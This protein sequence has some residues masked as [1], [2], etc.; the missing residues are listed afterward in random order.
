MVH[1]V[2]GRRQ[3]QPGAGSLAGKVAIVT[4]AGRP[5]GIGE[6]IALE[7]AAAGSH[8]AVV[9]VC[10]DPVADSGERFGQW[11]ELCA[12]AERIAGHGVRG[13]PVKAD[14]LQEEDVRTL[15]SRVAGELGGID[16]LCNNAAGGRGAGPIEPVPVVDIELADWRYTVD[17]NLTTAFLCSKHVARHMITSARGGVIVNLSSI[18]ARRAA[19]GVAGY[20]AGKMGVIALTRTLA[21]ELAEHGIRVNAIAPGVTDTP[22]V[23]QRV[24]HLSASSGRTREQAF[25]QWTA[26]I[27]LQRAARPQEMAA[28][29]AFLASE[30]ASY[31]TGQTI[32][33]DGGLVPD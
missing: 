19:A 1:E 32:S 6:A 29:V 21:I 5:G 31:L 28:V 15:V 25:A 4:G 33:V 2:D 20:T 22:W 11:Q 8:V 17:A 16:V 24:A 27:P 7:L 14:L 9:D 13:L 3:A 23:Q 10:R 30:G 12:L 18:A 26:S